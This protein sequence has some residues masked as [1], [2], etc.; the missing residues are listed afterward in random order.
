[1]AIVCGQCNRTFETERALEQHRRD[2][3]AHAVTYD[4]EECNR[5]FGTERALEQ[6]CR[7]S[8]AHAV[9][10]NCEECNRTFGTERALEQHRRDS[11]THVADED[12]EGLERSFDIR[13]SRD[14]DVSS[15]LRQ[16]GL[17]FKFFPIDDPHGWLKEHDTSIMGKFT[18]TNPSC[19]SLR[20]TSKHIAISIRQYPG[21]RYNARIYYQRCESC[22]SLSVPE[23]DDSYAER[24]SYR[25]AKWSGIAVRE[26][27]SSDRSKRPHQARLCEG[28]KYGHCQQ[29]RL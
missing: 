19:S 16:Y 28:C 6:H 1:M 25:L 29:S 12:A 17:S 24:V 23:L 8:P 9:T 18:C 7:D 20:W 11:P 2:S 26:P 27:P 22:D 5:T 4:R 14:Q 3:P 10:Y 15:L 13:P 21:L